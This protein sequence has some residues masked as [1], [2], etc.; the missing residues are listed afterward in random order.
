MRLKARRANEITPA[1]PRASSMFLRQRYA[2]RR[3]MM[4]MPAPLLLVVR[5]ISRTQERVDQVTHSP[6]WQGAIRIQAQAK[7]LCG[8]FLS[9]PRSLNPAVH[10]T[11]DSTVIR[12]GQ[13]NWWKKF[14]MCEQSQETDLADSARDAHPPLTV[15][16]C[17]RADQKLSANHLPTRRR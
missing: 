16:L 1:L 7:R 10:R 15:Y 17:A 4:L 11:T 6:G 13:N 3:A 8:S 14:L 2:C 12:K 5:P 9:Q